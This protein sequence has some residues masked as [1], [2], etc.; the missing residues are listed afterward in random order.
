MTSP[1]Y[2]ARVLALVLLML[3]AIP[4]QAGTFSRAEDTRPLPP[5]R[6]TNWDVFGVDLRLGGTFLMGNVDH[7]GLSADLGLS[8][9]M[10]PA[11]SLFLS[12]Q[13]DYASFGGTSKLDAETGTLLYAWGVHKMVNLFAYSTHYRNPF[14]DIKYRTT[15]SGGLCIH[16]FWAKVF[17]PILI[18]L[19][20][21]YEYEIS[22]KDELT[23]WA[24]RATARLNF[25]L[26]VND[27]LSMGGDF[28]YAP[29]LSDFRDYRVYGEF[30]FETK[31]TKDILAFRVTFADEYDS[32][33]QA[34]VEKN[35][36]SLI[37]AFVLRV[38]K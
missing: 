12:G 11:H 17:D 6:W 22:H 10:T 1:R 32:M 7:L 31:I 23:D 19:G 25:H 16:S 35:D 18:S 9:R 15:N 5:E 34:G 24:L 38:G 28:W 4:V 37:G 14:Q 20:L 29:R 36:L 26:P 13:A 27:Y 30:Y 2:W 33:P 8:W 21:T 3:S